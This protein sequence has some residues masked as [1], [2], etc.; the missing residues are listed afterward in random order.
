ME[1]NKKKTNIAIGVV[2]YNPD[3]IERVRLCLQSVK[4]QADKIY[5]F[6]NSTQ[7]MELG[8]DTDVV[9]KSEN[10]NR[11]IAHALNQIMEMAEADGYDWVVTMDQDSILSDGIIEDFGRYTDRED[12]GIIC[13]QV[14]DK[15]RVYMEIRNDAEEE[16][17]DMCIT[18]S[19]CTSVRA[20]RKIG[21]YDDWLFIDLVDN[22]YCKR[23]TLSGYKILRLNKWVLDQQFGKIVPKSPARQR[24]WIGLSKI[25]HNE[26]VAKL[27]YRKYVSPLRVYYTCRNIL[28]V[29]RKMKNYGAVAYE[30]YNCKGYPGFWISFVIPSLL[31]ADTKWEVMKAI[32]KGT[33][34]GLNKKVEPWTTETI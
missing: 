15:R 32:V 24:F 21:K 9:Y 29:N 14:I 30:N 23:L 13:P 27:S 25:L 33:I 6:D 11:G 10:E 34:D 22:E 5:I 12:I 1:N 8:F 20:W 16:F 3:S 7:D 4:K 19:S 18:S 26:N 31:R 2:L 17:I 28:Y